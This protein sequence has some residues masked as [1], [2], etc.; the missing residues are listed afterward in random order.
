MFTKTTKLAR[1]TAFTAAAGLLVSHAIPV[2]AQSS[3][4]GLTNRPLRDIINDIIV[5]LLGISTGIA[6][7]F[8]IIGGIYYITAAGDQNQMETA[9]K[10]LKYA[11][12]GIF[13][14][15]ISYAIVKT[16]ANI[17]G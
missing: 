3:N 13:V 9:K 5:W 12:I 8:M 17:I 16:I 14:V 2:L 11:I 6:V 4:Y 7:L 1:I 10:I 15:G